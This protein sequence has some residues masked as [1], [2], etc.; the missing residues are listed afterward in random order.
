MH[1]QEHQ[2][3][4]HDL[5]GLESGAPI[6]DPALP[7]SRPEQAR[8]LAQAR[9]SA[10]SDAPEVPQIVIP[11]ARVI[12]TPTELSSE[13]TARLLPAVGK[14]GVFSVRYGF[15]GPD[16]L[17]YG[18]VFGTLIA[19]RKN[20]PASDAPRFGHAIE[21]AYVVIGDGA[22]VSLP[23]A[24]IS[25]FVETQSAEVGGIDETTADQDGVVKHVCR[26]S[27]IFNAEIVIQPT[28]APEATSDVS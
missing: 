2:P 23:L 10:S 1:D 15:I 7:R 11:R 14:V 20:L 24:S 17:V 26:R 18:A 25:A 13:A 19:I 22:T 12:S 6:P 21:C 27:P 16:G 5:T 9:A 28:P 4:S 8:R 3:T